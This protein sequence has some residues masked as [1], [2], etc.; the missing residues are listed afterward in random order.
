MKHKSKNIFQQLI[1]NLKSKACKTLIL[2]VYNYCKEE[3][4]RKLTIS[5]TRIIL[6]ES[7]NFINNQIK[8]KFW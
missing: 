4:I 2:K 7:L 8:S 5:L 1:K 6:Y 3:L